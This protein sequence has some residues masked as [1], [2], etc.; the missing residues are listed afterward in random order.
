MI[1]NKAAGNDAIRGEV[2]KADI[3]HTSTQLESLL[4]ITLDLKAIPTHG[5]EGLVAKLPKKGD[6]TKCGNWRG[7]TLMSIPATNY[8]HPYERHSGPDTRGRTS[9]I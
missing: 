1:N 4:K 6:L 7:L 5:E 8:Y 2:L 9:R 3:D